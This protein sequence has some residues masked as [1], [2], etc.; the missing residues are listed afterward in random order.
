MEFYHTG[1]YA[2]LYQLGVQKQESSAWHGY[3]CTKK[4]ITNA[5]NQLLFLPNKCHR[6]ETASHSINKQQ[7]IS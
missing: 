3:C 1:K 2:L 6:K 5:Q 7:S 4:L